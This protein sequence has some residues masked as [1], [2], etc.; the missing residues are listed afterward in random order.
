VR[1]TLAVV[2][3]AVASAGWHAAVATPTQDE[4]ETQVEE[5][6]RLYEVGCASCHGERGEGIAQRGPSLADAGEASA[7]Y[8]L[9]T[10]R[11]PLTDTADQPQRKD[12]AYEA[13]EIDALVA[14]VATLGEGAPLPD[15]DLDDAD[16]AHGG[17]LFRANCAPCHSAAGSG[18]ALSYG[19]AAPSLA[20]SE[21]L[22]TAAA[23]R[24]GPGEM[25]VFGPDLVRP[26]EL[27]DVVRYVRY[28]QDPE[29][30]GGLP[31]GRI[32]PIPEGLVAWLVGVG[33][34][35]LAVYWIGSR[36]TSGG[37]V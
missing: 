10:G 25:P 19:R 2:A 26:G 6:R 20:D 28:L 18:G 14:Y 32:G 12:P 15:V 1:S 21:P 37:G 24:A 11:M 13:D 9:S 30:P 3:I 22:E 34:L 35:L 17:E 5:G 16:V 23:M 33:G 27:D 29:D 4:G 8:Y 36:R 7:Y 31:L